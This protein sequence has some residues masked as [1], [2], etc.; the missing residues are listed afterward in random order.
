MTQG[1][2]ASIANSP[3]SHSALALPAQSTSGDPGLSAA[4]KVAPQPRVYGKHSRILPSVCPLETCEDVFP[5]EPSDHLT[6]LWFGKPAD[7]LGALTR[8]EEI[9]SRIKYELMLPRAVADGYPVEMDYEHL[10]KRVEDAHPRILKL[11]ERG[12]SNSFFLKIQEVEARA[13]E[14]AEIASKKKNKAQGKN[15]S[16]KGD[17]KGKKPFTVVDLNFA[18]QDQWHEAIAE[19]SRP[20]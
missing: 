19:L 9:C 4:I 15:D 5:I 13:K 2:S 1:N 17:K 16:K 6:A 8:E 10:S 3:P 11:M 14:Q 20:G 18:A 7:Q 12:G